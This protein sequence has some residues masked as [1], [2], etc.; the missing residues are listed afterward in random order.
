MAGIAHELLHNRVF[1][2]TK[3]NIVLYKF[4]M[5]LMMSNYNYFLYTH[6]KH[7]SH[8]LQE[9]D[10]KE[11]VKEKLSWLVLLSWTLFDIR[12]FLSR[13]YFLI[14]NALGYYPRGIELKRHNV[15]FSARFVLFF[16]LSVVLIS[17]FTQSY[18]LIFYVTSAPFVGTLLNKVLAVNQHFGLSNEGVDSDDYFFNCRTIIL[19]KYIEF[20]YA[21]MNY[22]VE[23][24]Y[25][26]QVPYY[27]LREV[28]LLMI[29]KISFKN[30]E[31]GLVPS[32]KRL[33]F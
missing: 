18:F 31:S 29:E 30:C 3:V 17:V 24:H 12:S 32:F 10:P 15:V 14:W 11:L 4:C 23:H 19:P 27:N 6:W 1:T 16:H 8:T 20:A 26:P 28:H 22:H 7:H 13:I 33:F 9:E 2:S 5:L 21:S 25:F